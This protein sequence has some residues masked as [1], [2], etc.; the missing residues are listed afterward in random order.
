M[1]SS[2]IAYDGQVEAEQQRLSRE[3]ETRKSQL[4]RQH[5]RE[6]EE[7]KNKFQVKKESLK[8]QMDDE[9]KA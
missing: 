2:F 8:D 4:Q 5:D 6:V 1:V 9:V 3:L 7:M